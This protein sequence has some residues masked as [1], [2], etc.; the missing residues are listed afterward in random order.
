MSTGEYAASGKGWKRR[1]RSGCLSPPRQRGQGACEISERDR[2]IRRQAGSTVGHGSV[3]VWRRGSGRSRCCCMR[4][5]DR[6]DI[7]ITVHAVQARFL[8][9]NDERGGPE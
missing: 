7:N 2:E 8:I 9:M 3:V 6:P 4:G 5:D 1:I